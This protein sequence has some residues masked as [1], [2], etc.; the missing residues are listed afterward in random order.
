MK[1]SIK[2]LVSGVLAMGLMGAMVSAAGEMFQG[3]S[4]INVMVDGKPL[5]LDVP[6]INFYGRTLLPL[7]KVAEVAGM[8]VEWDG[9]TNTAKLT[10]TGPTAQEQ[11]ELAAA[12]A[13][14]AG[15]LAANKS[16]A[17]LP[18]TASTQDGL[19]FSLHEVQV[20]T[21]VGDYSAAKPGNQFLVLDL[22]VYNG[23]KGNENLNP[24]DVRIADTDSRIYDMTFSTLADQVP[25]VTLVPGDRVRGRLVFEIPEKVAL[26]QV[27]LSLDA[28]RQSDLVI[29]VR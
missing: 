10:R 8:N 17:A 14:L 20:T 19:V 11:A 13:E 7:R 27:R 2:F 24:F 21:K 4:V 28:F 9:A 29:R 25:M 1:K 26:G 18:L 3:F 12:K 22:S 16:G 15:Y 5:T 23:T 6:A